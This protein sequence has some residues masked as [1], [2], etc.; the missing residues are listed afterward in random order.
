MA[1]VVQIA[2]TMAMGEILM[3]EAYL[4]LMGDDRRFEVLSEPAPMR[5][6]AQ[7]RLARLAPAQA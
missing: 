2:N 6:D 3:S 1:K 7:G 4:P 5:F